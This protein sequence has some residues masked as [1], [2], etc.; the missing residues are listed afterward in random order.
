M[1]CAHFNIPAVAVF[2]PFGFFAA[3]AIRSPNFVKN[4]VY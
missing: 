2:A 4:D 3:F 1:Q